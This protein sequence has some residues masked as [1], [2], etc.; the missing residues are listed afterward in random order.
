[1]ASQMQPPTARQLQ[2]A[3]TALEKAFNQFRAAYDIIPTYPPRNP[4][5]HARITQ[6]CLA[7]MT[8]RA[9]LDGAL[10]LL[11][12]KTPPPQKDMHESM[13]TQMTF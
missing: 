3:K 11:G 10:W 5:E 12:P 6:A 9:Y 8:G 7:I 2:D 4:K 1:M 13:Q